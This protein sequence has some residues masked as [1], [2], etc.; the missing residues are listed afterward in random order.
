M[1][2]VE[3]DFDDCPFCDS[4]S[5]MY[6]VEEDVSFEYATAF[7]D[8]IA[9]EF[10]ELQVRVPVTTCDVCGAKFEGHDSEVIRD[11]AILDLRARLAQ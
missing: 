3:S 2:E 11:K 6:V 1:T 10:V 7:K 4:T 8:G 5:C 9:S